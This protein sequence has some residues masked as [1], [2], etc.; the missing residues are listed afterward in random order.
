VAAAVGRP[1][2]LDPLPGAALIVVR[3]LDSGRREAEPG[4]RPAIPA[5]TEG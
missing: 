2:G 5:N 4:E 1:A 3:T